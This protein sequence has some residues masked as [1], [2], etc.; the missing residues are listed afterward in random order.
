MAPLGSSNITEVSP[1]EFIY[2]NAGIAEAYRLTAPDP[3][4]MGISPLTTGSP[5][6]PQP[7][8]NWPMVT[9]VFWTNEF[10]G[11]YFYG[12]MCPA[13]A[14]HSFNHMPDCWCVE[15]TNAGWAPGHIQAWHTLTPVC[16]GDRICIH[17]HDFCT[18]HIPPWPAFAL[19]QYSTNSSGWHTNLA[20]G[21][22]TNYGC[23]GIWTVPLL[24]TYS[25][26]VR[27]TNA[28]WMVLENP[29]PC[30]FTWQTNLNG[31]L[32]PGTNWPPWPAGLFDGMCID[33]NNQIFPDSWWTNANSILNLTLGY[34]PYGGFNPYGPIKSD[35][36]WTTICDAIEA[37][38][39]QSNF[40]LGSP[41][42]GSGYP[43]SQPPRD[44]DYVHGA[45]ERAQ[46]LLP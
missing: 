35:K 42:G 25:N 27:E 4:A 39:E 24:T 32:P 45:L 23:S 13:A 40:V 15:C 3:S 46:A 7:Y 26:A 34:D 8:T 12:L 31:G 30:Q 29:C 19:I 41:F 38:L 1:G 14:N 22:M 5:P 44:Y 2:E 33:T 18:N 20:F 21:V 36:Q 43:I 28:C 9:N 16:V 37:F 17:W 6:S 11:T 10:Y